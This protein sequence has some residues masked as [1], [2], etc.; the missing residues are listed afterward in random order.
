MPLNMVNRGLVRI[1]S[2]NAGRGLRE[3][4]IRMGIFEGDV[5]E[6]VMNSFPGPVFVQKDGVRIGLGAGMASKIFVQPVEVIG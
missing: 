2:I 6:V 1:V 4:L 5:I 3:R